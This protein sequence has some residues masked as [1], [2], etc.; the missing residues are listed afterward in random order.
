MG[1][2]ARGVARTVGSSSPPMAAI[3][4]AKITGG[5]LPDGIIQVNVTVSPADSN[6]LYIEAAT[7][8][9]VGFYRSDDGGAHWVH[10]PRGRFATGGSHWRR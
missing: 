10:A 2:T 6:R 4:G 9:G 3:T 1:K 7:E 8:H 5:G